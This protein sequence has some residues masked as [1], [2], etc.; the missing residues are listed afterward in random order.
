M[1][2]TP[3]MQQYLSIK[4]QHADCILFFRLV[5]FYEMFFDDAIIASKD[6]DVALTKRSS[7]GAAHAPMCGVPYHAADGY[8]AKLIEKGHKVAICEQ[9]EDPA[10]AIGI[11][12]REV[13]RI[14][15]PGTLL[16][17]SMLSETDN[18]Y[19]VSLYIDASGTGLSYCDISTGEFAAVAF[20]DFLDA[21]DVI[22][23]LAKIAPREILVNDFHPDADAFVNENDIS[24]MAHMTS[25]KEEY[26]NEFHCKTAIQNHFNTAI[27][28]SLGLGRQEAPLLFFA[29]GALL[30]YLTDTQKQQMEHLNSIRIYTASSHMT[31][32]RAT[33][34]HLEITNSLTDRKGYSLLSVLDKTC[35]AMGARKMKQWLKEPL[36]RKKDIDARLHAVAAFLEHPIGLN[37]VRQALKNVYDLERLCARIAC[38]TANGRD[39]IALKN[40]IRNVPDVKAELTALHDPLL[41]AYNEEIGMFTDLCKLIE[42]ALVDEPP[43]SVREGGLIRTGFSEDL[44]ELTDSIREGR[45]WIAS[46]EPKERERTG[47]KNL[48]V[49]FNKVFGY[50]IDISKS[51]I[52]FVPEHYIRKQTLVNS[53]RYITQELKEIETVVLSAETRINDLEYQLFSELRHRVAQSV[54]AIQRTSAALAAIDVLASFAEVSS[55]LHYTM[56][57]ILEGDRIEIQKGRHP[58]IEQTIRNGVFVSNDL[59]IDR[60]QSLLL[61]TGPNMS[62]KSTYMRQMALIV[63]MAQSGC[64]VPAERAEIGLCDRIYTR[65]GASDNI[66]QGQSTF[67][68]E[69]AELAHILHTATEKSLVILDEIGRGTSTYDGLSIAWAV[70]EHL[71]RPDKRVRTLFATHYHELTSLSET[72][73]ALKNLNVDVV[74]SDGTIVFLHKIVEGS[75]NRSYGI[76]VARLAGVPEDV[77]VQAEKKLTDLESIDEKSHLKTSHYT[78]RAPEETMQLSLFSTVMDQDLERKL[79]NLDVM[80][81][82]PAEAIDTLIELQRMARERLQ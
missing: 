26:Y 64:F 48:K 79:A 75:A 56:P 76:H 28:H 13:V 15:T 59:F 9:V 12:K 65:I 3:M 70:C 7:G 49:G 46:L 5:D 44:D 24:D 8:I 4:E 11:V 43:V 27:E 40:S 1:T 23:E 32:D 37:N 62:G 39:M 55:K 72:I 2:L 81:T 71:T 61:I 25:G 19:L 36:N 77:L 69:M 47:I 29:T 68:V 18:N 52:S 50:Y 45:E 66:A 38:G 6:M 60:K 33:L 10:A 21:G 58:V 16:S 73:P 80:H 22:A 42:L 20:S 74:E 82:T 17:Q 35:T 53:E 67:Y 34:A 30:N 57:A 41:D 63:L 51:N 31:L 14:I 78:D 54:A